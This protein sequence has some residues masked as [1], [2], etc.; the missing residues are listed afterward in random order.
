M[1]TLILLLLACHNVQTYVF[2]V[3]S[4][5]PYGNFTGGS[6]YNSRLQYV[7]IPAGV[8]S[9]SFSVQI[10]NDNA[11]EGYETFF[12]YISP[13]SYNNVHL[14]SQ[15]RAKVTIV[16]DDCEYLCIYFTNCSP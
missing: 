5:F 1:F 3:P 16:D 11:I 12:L 14:G 2:C 7:T 8:T 13:H 10:Y 6:D 9:I 4:S 15:N